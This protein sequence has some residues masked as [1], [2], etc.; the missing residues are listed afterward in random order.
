MHDN[1]K[2]YVLSLLSAISIHLIIVALLALQWHIPK[3]HRYSAKP[4]QAVE[5]IEAVAVDSAALQAEIHKIQTQRQAK[6]NAALRRQRQVANQVKEARIARRKEQQRLQQ[7]KKHMQALAKQQAKAKLAAAKKLKALALQHKQA[8]AKLAKMKKAQLALKKQKAT[9][10]KQ[11]KARQEALKK[12]KAKKQHVA[13]KKP[14]PAIKKAKVVNTAKPKIKT[15][16]ALAQ[17]LAL[18]KVTE[19][20]KGLILQTIATH[21]ILPTKINKKI[22]CRFKIHLAPGGKVLSVSLLKSSGDPALDRSARAAVY[23]ASPLPVPANSIQ[24]EKFRTFNLTVR[25]EKVLSTG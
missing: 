12:A 11:V 16:K 24:F 17:R 25:P 8:E 18:A 13:T 22:S 21:W 10:E 7:M 1:S 6:I 20:Y 2:S 15:A 19:H 5:V 4:K 23:K 3:T 14:K 9:L